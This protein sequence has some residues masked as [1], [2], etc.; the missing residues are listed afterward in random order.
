V[1][2]ERLQRACDAV[3]FTGDFNISLAKQPED[4]ELHVL[5]GH[6]QSPEKTL[7]LDVPTGF[8]VQAESGCGLLHWP[9]ERPLREAF[10]DVHKWGER[11]GNFAEG[12][13]SS[14]SSKRC[15]WIDFMFYS[16]DSLELKKVSL[17][18]TPPHPL[19][20]P[21]YPS[22]HLPISAMFEFRKL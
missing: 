22:D 16:A 15:N 9:R 19:P 12:V 14:F 4:D 11:V 8:E 7:S 13:C 21:D 2:T 18:K 10:E 5:R 3:I 6:L 1:Q 17:N 20:A